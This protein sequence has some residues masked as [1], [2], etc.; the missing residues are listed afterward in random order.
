[1]KGRGGFKLS[2]GALHPREDYEWIVKGGAYQ[3]L[4]AEVA[5]T[6]VPRIDTKDPANSLILRK[7]TASVPHGGGQRFKKTS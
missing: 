5:G 1:V 7:A 2:S 6:R 3:V 4:T